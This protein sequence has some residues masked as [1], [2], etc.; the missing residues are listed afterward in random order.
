[1]PRMSESRE[2]TI[3]TAARLLQRQ[4]Y[5]ATG[6]TQIL[7]ESGAPKGSFYFHFPGGKEQL[8]AEAVALAG[9]EM[10]A[11]I[12]AV[13]A[14][15]ADPAKAVVALGK[16]WS[17]WL[18]GSDY[19]EGCP[20]TTVALEQSSQS[21]ILRQACAVV[22]GSWHRQLRDHFVAAGHAPVRAGALA[23][24]V[25]CS[26]EGA[27]VIARSERSTASFSETARLL[28]EVVAVGV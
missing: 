17:S 4:G 7:E 8:G 18:A 13:L 16:T 21:S 3:V 22:F 6:L 25:L 24:L 15:H 20:I 11:I 5:A 23:R 1:M 12:G 19:T 26:F 27:F 9:S 14:R 28:A 2:N 10:N